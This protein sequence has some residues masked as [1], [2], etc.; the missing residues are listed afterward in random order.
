VIGHCFV[1]RILVGIEAGVLT[2]FVLE[3]KIGGEKKWSCRI[4]F[5]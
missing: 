5:D 2:I 1:A 3:L 4:F